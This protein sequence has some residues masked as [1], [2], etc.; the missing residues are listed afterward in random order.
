MEKEK[1]NENENEKEKEKEKERER[2]KDE[3]EEKIKGW[4]RGKWEVGGKEPKFKTTTKT[5]EKEVW[6]ETKGKR[7]RRIVMQGTKK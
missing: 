6:G 2:E 4:V 3:G 1:E 7:K 5:K